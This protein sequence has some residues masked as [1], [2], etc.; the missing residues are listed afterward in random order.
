MLRNP[1]YS[2]T[3]V[4]RKTYIPDFLEQKAKINYGEVEQVVVE[5]RHEP[6][7]SKEDF[8]KIQ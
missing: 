2:S 8:K 1:F 3:N 5:G 4:N 6:L 7:V